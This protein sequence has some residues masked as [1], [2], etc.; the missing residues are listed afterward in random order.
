MFNEELRAIRESKCILYDLLFDDVLLCVIMICI[1]SPYGLFSLFSIFRRC[2]QVMM[3]FVST[4]SIMRDLLVF[5]CVFVSSVSSVLVVLA[6][7][8]SLCC[9]C[10]VLVF[11]S[12]LCLF[13]WFV[14][15]L[16][17]PQLFFLLVFQFSW[18][19]FLFLSLLVYFSMCSS[20][21]LFLSC[22]ASHSRSFCCWRGRSCIILSG[23][24]VLLFMVSKSPITSS[25][26]ITKS[27]SLMGDPWNTPMLPSSFPYF[28]F[29]RKPRSY[30]S[31]SAVFDRFPWYSFLFECCP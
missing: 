31:S 12:L 18:F 11:S 17:S 20:C 19:I 26:Y 27:S 25:R 21:F 1:I 7:S 28:V 14:V 2:I 29:G 4:F 16:L 6:W 8:L 3:I 23:R 13:L 24:P 15:H 9:S 30:V 5:L 10:P 22:I